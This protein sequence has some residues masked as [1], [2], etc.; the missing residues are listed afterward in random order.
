MYV[1]HRANDR[2][3]IDVNN[4]FQ[5]LINEEAEISLWD[6]FFSS[7]VIL[8]SLYNAGGHFFFFKFLD[9]DVSW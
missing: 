5:T 9:V 3:F 7:R 6:R 1:R 8:Y 2:F 4:V